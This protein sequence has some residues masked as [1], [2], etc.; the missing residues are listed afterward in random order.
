MRAHVTRTGWHLSRVVLASA[1]LILATCTPAHADGFVG[2]TT[3]TFEGYEEG[4][5]ITN[6]YEEQGLIFSGASPDELPFI[7]RDGVSLTNPVL[8]GYPRF[9][10]PIKGEFVVPGSSQP[11]TVNGLA[12][13]IGYIDDPDSV[14][15]TVTTKTGSETIVANEYGFNHLESNASEITGFSVEETSYDEAGFEI[16]NVSFTPG[17]P[18]APPP[19]SPPPAPTP[20]PPPPPTP[21]APAAS[22]CPAYMV[23]DSRGS[24]ENK[25]V[26]GHV[27]PEISP[28]AAYFASELRHRHPSLSLS[29]VSNP[30][31]AV[32]LWG[33]PGQVINLIGAG[34]GI[35]PLGAYHD[36]VVDGEKWL[37]ADVQNEVNTCGGQT[38]IVLIGYSQGAQ[39]TGDVYQRYVS[40]AEKTDILAVVL[41]GDPY[42]DPSDKAA[43]R[44]STFWPH[45][46][47]LG[48]RPTFGG[49]HRV[50]SYC[51]Y[52]DIICQ[53]SNI[54]EIAKYKLSQHE[55]Y[56]PDAVAA[57]KH[58]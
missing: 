4:V 12:M 42:F 34:L 51:H 3:I 22:D 31:P 27:I 56:P 32:G 2:T 46:G 57:A 19:Q 58:F 20:P 13:D 53:R 11:T 21:A 7:A 25:V 50:L 14:Q 33:S 8:S 29:L 41:F 35:G 39:V 30:Y 47:V 40:S 6:Q 37:R 9:H 49:D 45:A 1:A 36:S 55:N 5:P 52:H 26:H 15:L 38:H 10:G 16:D 48:E 54:V 28:P 18:P 44:G 24:G 43:D 17:A 23:I